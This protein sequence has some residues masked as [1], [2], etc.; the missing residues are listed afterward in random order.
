MAEF[1]KALRSAGRKCAELAWKAVKCKPVAIFG[2]FLALTLFLN[3]VNSPLSVLTLMATYM[4]G[5]ILIFWAFTFIR[6]G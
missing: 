6:I 3:A 1:N 4:S 5:A 2:I